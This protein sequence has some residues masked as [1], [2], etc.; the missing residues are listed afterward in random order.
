MHQAP[1][2]LVPI[3]WTGEH[4][5]VFAGEVP[6]HIAIVMDGNGRWANCRGLPRVE[7]HREGEQALLNVVE[8]A[9]WSAKRGG[10]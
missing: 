7:G 10:R 8:V 1:R 5:P 6:Q 2:E 9:R 3:D 4:P